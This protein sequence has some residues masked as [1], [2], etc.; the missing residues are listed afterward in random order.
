MKWLA[1]VEVEVVPEAVGVV[2]VVEVEVL[3][4]VEG[5]VEVVE[6]VVEVEAVV[7]VGETETVATVVSVTCLF[8]L[9][10]RLGRMMANQTMTKMIPRMR[11]EM[12]VAIRIKR[13]LLVSQSC[14]NLTV[15]G[16]S[17]PSG[18]LEV[19]TIELQQ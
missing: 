9:A 4:V 8:S 15:R 3:E 17:G 18:R 11:R 10:L 14:P 7:E 12:S 5:V 6:G 19:S 1:V 13:G 16:T 2:D